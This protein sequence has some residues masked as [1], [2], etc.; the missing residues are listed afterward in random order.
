MPVLQHALN[1]PEK[2][3][4][5]CAGAQRNLCGLKKT[6]KEMPTRHKPMLGGPYSWNGC[7][8]LVKCAEQ[9]VGAGDAARPP[10]PAQ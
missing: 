10:T 7:S 6:T 9:Q 2:C 8:Q 1:I 4:K 3:H 5:L